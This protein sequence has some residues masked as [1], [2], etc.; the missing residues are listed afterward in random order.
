MVVLEAKHE[1]EEGEV[2]VAWVFDVRE[3]ERR[4]WICWLLGVFGSGLL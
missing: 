2:T 4:A 3:E 1:D